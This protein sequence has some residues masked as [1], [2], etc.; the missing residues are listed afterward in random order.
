MLKCAAKL[1]ERRVDA[2]E[3]NAQQSF[4]SRQSHKLCRQTLPRDEETMKCWIY[5]KNVFGKFPNFTRR[6]RLQ[7]FESFTLQHGHPNVKRSLSQSSPCLHYGFLGTH[8]QTHVHSCRGAWLTAA[9]NSN[10][11]HIESP[12]SASAFSVDFVLGSRTLRVRSA[13]NRAALACFCGGGQV[14]RQNSVRDVLI[15]S[16]SQMACVSPELEKPGVLLPP[17]TSPV[18][19]PATPSWEAGSRP[20]PKSSRHPTPG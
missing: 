4:W 8:K 14:V 10:D 17:R 2:K 11:S 18:P 19:S 16:A 1:D 7:L 5:F 3:R 15:A 12:C 20:G 9:P 13:A 6:R